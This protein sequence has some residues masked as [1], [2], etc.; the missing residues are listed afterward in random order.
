MNYD[1]L[2]DEEALDIIKKHD[3]VSDRDFAELSSYIEDPASVLYWLDAD[4]DFEQA[5]RIQGLPMDTPIK[6]ARGLHETDYDLLAFEVN[7]AEPEHI[8]CA[9]CGSE[10]YEFQHAVSNYTESFWISE[11][12]DQ[13]Y[14]TVERSWEM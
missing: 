5:V 13:M 3:E 1:K 6:V 12:G 4:G 10:L 11:Y 14:D 2:T 8:E 7:T 9:G